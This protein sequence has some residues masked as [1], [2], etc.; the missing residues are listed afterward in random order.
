MNWS[1]ENLPITAW[2]FT[3]LVSDV[4]YIKSSKSSTFIK[5]ATK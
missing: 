1:E 4:T 2:A 5:S 3:A